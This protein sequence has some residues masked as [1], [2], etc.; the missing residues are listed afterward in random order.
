MLPQSTRIK[1]QIKW[2][3]RVCVSSNVQGLYHEAALGKKPK[4]TEGIVT[5]FS[6]T[7]TKL[8]N[9]AICGLC[10]CIRNLGILA[11]NYSDT[12]QEA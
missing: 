1:L 7:V 4:I 10:L 5:F 3:L 2:H 12:G 11:C 8:L 9:G 6:Q